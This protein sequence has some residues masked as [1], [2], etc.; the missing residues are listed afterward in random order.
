MEIAWRLVSNSAVLLT[1][2][3]GRGKT[4]SDWLVRYGR[5]LRGHAWV[6]SRSV[7]ETHLEGV[8]NS[9]IADDGYACS[10]RLLDRT[11]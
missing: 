2:E 5:V 1:I 7:S 10:R 6:V 9:A 11:T 8:S 4:I 3:R